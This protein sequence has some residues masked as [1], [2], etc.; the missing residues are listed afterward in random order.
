VR[1]TPI[2]ASD[3]DEDDAVGPAPG[4]GVIQVD[5]QIVLVDE[6]TGR[7][8]ALNPTASIVWECLDG[9]TPIGVI[10]D[11]VHAEFGGPRGTIADDITQLARD[12]GTLGFLDNVARGLAFVPIDVRYTSADECEPDSDPTSRPP[13]FDSRYVAAPPNG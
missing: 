8:H 9:Q 12:L 11:D 13:S 10:I 1:Q 3:L 7:A 5:E 4:V 2:E 6:L